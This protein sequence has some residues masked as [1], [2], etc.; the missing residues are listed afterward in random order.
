G[1]S[2]GARGSELRPLLPR[3]GRRRLRERPRAGDRAGTGGADGRLGR[4]G[5]LERENEVFARPAGGIAGCATVF[6][7]KR[8]RGRTVATVSR[9]RLPA[10]AVVTV[11]AAALGG[12]AA[13]GIGKGTGW[14]D[15][16]TKTVVVRAAAPRTAALP[17][18]ATSKVAP[19]A[20]R[21]SSC[22]G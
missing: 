22:P 19:H 12:G 14:L 7:G 4:A 2:C 18:S 20:R 1:D 3:R 13:L 10:L 6:T 5:R 21:R 17:A 11:A 15:Q 8:T 9:M 16:G